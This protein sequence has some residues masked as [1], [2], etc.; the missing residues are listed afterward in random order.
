MVY[1]LEE[2]ID[3]LRVDALETIILIED[4]QVFRYLLIGENT[5]K[6]CY[7]NEK[8]E[9]DSRYFI[10]YATGKELKI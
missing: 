2:T 9:K 7:L 5:E 6:V 8:Q 10:E 1:G 4:L 3:A